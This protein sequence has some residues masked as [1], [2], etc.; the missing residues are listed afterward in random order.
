MSEPT[1]IDEATGL[2]YVEFDGERRLLAKLPPNPLKRA[3]FPPF[4]SAAP[5]LP[6]TQWYQVSRREMM[7]AD[8]ITDQKNHGSCT[9]F[10]SSAAMARLRVILGQPYRRLSGSFVYSFING[11]RDQG[12]M[13]SDTLEVLQ[14]NGTCLESEA[15]WDA[16]YPSRI[17]QSAFATAKRFRLGE[18][19]QV[20]TFDEAVSAI[21]LNF[22]V[23]GAVMVGNRFATLNSDGV[24]GFD[25]GLGNHAVHFDGVKRL[26]SGEWV[27][28]MPNSWGTQFG[29]AGRCYLTQ[30]HFESVQ[31]DSYAMRNVTEDTED[32]DDSPVAG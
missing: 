6:R 31:Q 11:G 3:A 13:I 7:G 28:D 22:V 12:A 17:P 8:Y 25:P 4:V 14:K 1:L 32:T 10:A 20:N 15:G 2:P 30:K 24:A 27:L 26:A 16:I 21:L 5:V 18:A 19:Y 29:Q 9:G 23:V